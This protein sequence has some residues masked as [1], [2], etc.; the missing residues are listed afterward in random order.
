MSSTNPPKFVVKEYAEGMPPFVQI[1]GLT[2]PVSLQAK[3]N[4]K[5]E[6]IRILRTEVTAATEMVFVGDV[7]VEIVWTIDVDERYRTH[8][9]ADIDNIVKPILDGLTGPGCL[10]IDDNQVQS[11]SASWTTP[12][13]LNNAM[14]D[15]RVE[16][17]EPDAIAHREHIVFVELGRNLCYPIH[18]ITDEAARMQI[19][20]IQ[21]L[22][23]AESRLIEL[24]LPAHEARAI[25]SIQR[26]FPRARL[27]GFEII[28]AKDY[29]K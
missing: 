13:M 4:R 18:A 16:S 17:L 24:G 8:L 19:A 21:K 25:R 7:R 2:D 27:Q 1:Y 28:N 9:V 14:I 12:P 10:L 23:D 20:G 5:S 15:I 11:L 29:L 6:Y 22:L 26:P 3:G